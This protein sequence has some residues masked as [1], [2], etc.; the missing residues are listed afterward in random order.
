MNALSN[1]IQDMWWGRI[2]SAIQPAVQV[3]VVQMQSVAVASVIHRVHL[4]QLWALIVSAIQNTVPITVVEIYSFQSVAVANVIPHVHLVQ[5]WGWI[6]NAIQPYSKYTVL[7]QYVHWV[8][9]VAKECVQDVY[10]VHLCCTRPQIVN[11][12]KIKGNMAL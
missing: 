7:L 10:K 12:I 8:Q 11:V 4:V 1:V 9:N 5:L 6:V 2:V 3:T